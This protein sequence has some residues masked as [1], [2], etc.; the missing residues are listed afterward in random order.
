[1]NENDTEGIQSYPHDDSRTASEIID[2]FVE[3]ADVPKENAEEFTELFNGVLQTTNEKF[4]ERIDRLEDQIDLIEERTVRTAAL[5]RV[6][7]EYGM[8][9][10]EVEE[11]VETVEAVDDELRG[12]DDE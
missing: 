8:S 6:L 12:D 3:S 1:M 11:L 7:L 9:G 5:K 2:S 10:E 4:E